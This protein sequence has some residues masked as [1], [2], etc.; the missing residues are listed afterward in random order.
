[1][2]K[3]ATLRIAGPA[4]Q[5]TRLYLR[6]ECP[7]ELLRGGPL[8]VTV[9]VNGTTLPPA[10]IRPGENAFEISFALPPEA[11]GKPELQVALEAARTFRP[12]AD[13]RD[14]ALAFGSFEIR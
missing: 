13:P 4:G 10:T 2:P 3:R 8:G 7:E 14:L 1:M 11:V 12:A 5:G 6:G 9:S